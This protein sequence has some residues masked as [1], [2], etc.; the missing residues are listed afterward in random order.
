MVLSCRVADPIPADPTRTF[1]ALGA[2]LSAIGVFCIAFGILQADSNGVL[3][4]VFLATG[5][6][7][8]L[9][10]FL[11]TRARERAGREPLL[12]LALF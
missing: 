3:M 9:W 11:Y 4:A 8:L 1:D 12:S 6:A 7:F 2:V 10:F 5:A